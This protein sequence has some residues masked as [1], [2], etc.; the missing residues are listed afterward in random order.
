MARTS[1]GGGELTLSDQL[2]ATCY[3]HI[4]PHIQMRNQAADF[5]RAVELM[6]PSYYVQ[7]AVQACR[8][9]AAMSVDFMARIYAEVPRCAK[10]FLQRMRPTSATYTEVS[11]R[12]APYLGPY[13]HALAQYAGR[14]Q[15][16]VHMLAE[17]RSS[18]H[19]NAFHLGRTAAE[20][21]SLFLGSLGTL[22]TTCGAGYLAGRH[23]DNQIEAARQQLEQEFREMVQSYD[24]AMTQLQST[25]IEMVSWYHDQIMAGLQQ[26]QLAIGYEQPS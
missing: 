2:N 1:S 18:F 4:V 11:N 8:D 14:H 24:E 20:V 7:F 3:D 9:V 17:T 21:S 22:L 10:G 23:V 6:A 26:A 12:L 19:E 16:F 13:Q 25:A 5:D 15:H